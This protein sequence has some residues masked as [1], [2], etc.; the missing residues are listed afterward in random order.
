MSRRTEMRKAISLFLVFSFLML[1]G[2]LHGQ[3]CFRG[4]PAPKCRFFTIIEAGYLLDS[5]ETRNFQHIMCEAG[6]MVNLNKHHA[7]GAT[8]YIY[9]K[10]ESSRGF[11]LRYRRWLGS[12]FS[13]DIA[14]GLMLADGRAHTKKPQ[15]TGHIGLNYKDI[16]ALISQV[17]IK[18]Y[19]SK[20]SE[21]DLSFGVKFGSYVGATTIAVTLIGELIYLGLKGGIM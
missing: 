13:L 11:K 7:L 2:L 9:P 18:R 10:E 5:K 14:P 12:S 3:L 19:R 15:F 16:V 17:D 4:K 21:F 8:F 20:E 6:L 1:P